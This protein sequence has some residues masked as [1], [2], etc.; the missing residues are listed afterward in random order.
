V[1]GGRALE[2]GHTLGATW[3]VFG[4]PRAMGNTTSADGGHGGAGGGA[5]PY[6]PCL[7]EAAWVRVSD[8]IKHVEAVGGLATEGLYRVSGLA[9]DVERGASFLRDGAGELRWGDLGIHEWAGAIKGCLRQHEPLTSYRLYDALCDASPAALPALLAA[10]PR[11][12]YVR[13]RTT[14]R[15]LVRV[16]GQ[17]HVNLMTASNLAKIW[18]GVLSRRDETGAVDIGAELRAASQQYKIACALLEFFASPA[19]ESQNP[20]S[21]R[22]MVPLSPLGHHHLAPVREEDGSQ[23]SGGGQ[24]SGRRDDSPGDGGPGGGGDAP[25]RSGS[26]SAGEL[27]LP[28]TGEFSALPSSSSLLPP[29]AGG[30]MRRQFSAEAISGHARSLDQALLRA[31]AAAS[32]SRGRAITDTSRL[33]GMAF[34]GASVSAAALEAAAVAAAHRRAAAVAVGISSG[35]GGGV[36]GGGDNTTSSSSAGSS[37]SATGGGHHPLGRQGLSFTA[38]ASSGAVRLDPKALAAALHQQQKRDSMVNLAGA[39]PVGDGGSDITGISGSG[40]GGSGVWGDYS[41]SGGGEL[42]YET[43]AAEAA[44]SLYAAG[45]RGGV[46]GSTTSA[47]FSISSPPQSPLQRAPRRGSAG[48]HGSSPLVLASSAG[49]SPSLAPL[50]AGVTTGGGGGGYGS[51]GAL[52]SGETTAGFGASSAG[53]GSAPQSSGSGSGS[54]SGG[55]PLSA[56]RRSIASVIIRSSSRGSGLGSVSGSGGGGGSAAAADGD[57]GAASL[58][59]QQHHHHQQQSLQHDPAVAAALSAAAVAGRPPAAHSHHHPPP[60]PS[61]HDSGGPASAASSPSPGGASPPGAHPHQQ[62]PQQHV[63]KTSILGRLLHRGGSTSE[64]TR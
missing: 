59:Q 5:S 39:A 29:D 46:G 50:P 22:L 13:L 49:T 19:S 3:A 2:H 38:R 34:D 53:A 57:G 35:G 44:A 23:H 58:Q 8:A 25:A 61:A 42:D 24:A 10:L 15:H 62:P 21:V 33:D 18:G 60:H 27:Q 36:G 56:A 20:A 9:T 37:V 14:C 7:P 45:A 48:G 40:G 17:A 52:G 54:G 1:S 51:G 28:S 16:A 64:G 55:G 43:I 30:P 31:A 6:R 4:A 32:H 26:R 12:W 11:E 41:A 63:R 47:G